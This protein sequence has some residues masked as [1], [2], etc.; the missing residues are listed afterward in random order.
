MRTIRVPTGGREELVDVTGA[1][2]EAV[3]SSGVDEGLCLVQALHTTC[4]V[5]VNE[6]AD[7]DVRADML[8]ALARAVPD[9]PSFRHAEGNSAAHVKSSLMGASVCLAVTGGRLALGTWQGIYLCEFDG[10][11]ERKLAVSV[12]AS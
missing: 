2:E 1:V 5:T 10:P 9:D 6:N 11:R 8:K 7:P 12:L 4:G 3:E